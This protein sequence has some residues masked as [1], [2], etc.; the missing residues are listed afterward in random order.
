MVFSDYRRSAIYLYIMYTGLGI[1]C[2][3]VTKSSLNQLFTSTGSG[4]VG[5]NNFSYN[6]IHREI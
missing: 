1:N 6:L 3:E 4:C 2:T 5:A